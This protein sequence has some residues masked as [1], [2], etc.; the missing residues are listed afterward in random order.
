MTQKYSTK[1]WCC[2]EISFLHHCRVVSRAEFGLRPKL[3]KR[4]GSN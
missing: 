2:G 3:E 1:L 4:F